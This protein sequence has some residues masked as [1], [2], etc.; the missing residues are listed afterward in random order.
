LQFICGGVCG[1]TNG[2]T[3]NG[4]LNN[5]EKKGKG[6]FSQFL[7]DSVLSLFWR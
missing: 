4:I 5:D 3:K 7:L 1:E 6:G 2:R